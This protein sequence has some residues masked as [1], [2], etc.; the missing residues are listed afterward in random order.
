VAATTCDVIVLGLGGMGSAAA[1]HLAGRGL[2]VAGVEQFTPAHDRGSSHGGTRI[3]R[4]AYF[5]DPSY[6]PLLLRAY[7]LWRELDP[8]LL[9]VTGGLMLSRAGEPVFAGALASA[10]QHGLAHEVYDAGALR[11]RY[12]SLRVADDL[13]GLYEAD[14]GVLLP[15]AC[16]RAHL[17]GAAA[18]GAD[19]RFGARVAAWEPGAV[20]LATGEVLR[21]PRLVVAAGAWARDLLGLPLRIERQ[22]VMWVPPLAPDLPVFIWSVGSPV[23]RD[24]YGLPDVTGQ[25]YKVGFHHG[26]ETIDPDA[27]RRPVSA[28]EVA[29]LRGVLRAHIPA[30]DAEPLATGTCMYSNTPD[31]HFALGLLPGEPGVAV[32][33]G[34]SGHGFKFCSVVGEILA[35]LACEGGTR[36]PIGPFALERLGV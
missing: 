17:A 24:I 19:L 25:G 30:L 9:R 8:S 28:E 20:R 18:R 22:W 12:P 26:G 36:H 27:P 10:R 1:Y 14:A 13:V 21:A 32:A 4:K 15:E 29:A 33:A 31:E 3:I 5:E 16:V 23:A 2:R 35:D 7:E 34:F 6:V 11:R